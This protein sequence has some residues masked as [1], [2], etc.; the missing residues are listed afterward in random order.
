MNKNKPTKNRNPFKINFK[1]TQKIHGKPK[2]EIHQYVGVGNESIISRVEIT[3][4]VNK[5]DKMIYK[6]F[7]WTNGVLM[8]YKK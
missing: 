6:I 7:R 2:K 3:R 1:S 5:E 8:E 4:E